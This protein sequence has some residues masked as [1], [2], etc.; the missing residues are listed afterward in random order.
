[1]GIVPNGGYRMVDTQSVK[2]IQWLS[3]M[4]KVLGRKIHFTARK[5]E[6]R[7]PENVKVDGFCPDREGK[8]DSLV[9]QYHGCYYHE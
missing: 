7:L 2:A 9:L 3:W 4:E 8:K 5:R 6:L 1:M